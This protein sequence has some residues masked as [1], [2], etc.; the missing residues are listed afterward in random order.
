MSDKTRQLEPLTKRTLHQ[1]FVETVVTQLRPDTLDLFQLE[2]SRQGREE[3]LVVSGLSVTSEGQTR[4]V[5]R[6]GESFYL[7]VYVGVS[8]L[9]VDLKAEFTLKLILVDQVTNNR[10]LFYERTY[11]GRLPYTFFQ[12][13]FAAEARVAGVFRPRAVTGLKETGLFHVCDGP[14][15]RIV[16]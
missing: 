14:Y 11:A 3:F 7:N 2:D 8:E 12:I 4:T 6:R 16:A 1:E 13:S 10:Q 9:L 5:L 15:F